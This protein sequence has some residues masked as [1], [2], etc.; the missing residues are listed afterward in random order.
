MRGAQSQKLSV[1]PL[2]W[3]MAGATGLKLRAGKSFAHVAADPV[4]DSPILNEP[5]SLL[6]K[7]RDGPHREEDMHP[8][9]RARVRGR[10]DYRPKSLWR[11]FQGG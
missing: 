2:E 6:G 11:L 10:T 3:M 7:W 8:S 5:P 9:V 4:S 1:I